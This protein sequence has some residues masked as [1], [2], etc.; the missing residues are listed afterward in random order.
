MKA[1]GEIV[2]FEPKGGAVIFT[3][4]LA[5]IE[6]MTRRMLVEAGKIK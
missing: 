3:D 5:P 2:E 4:D 1:A 6:R